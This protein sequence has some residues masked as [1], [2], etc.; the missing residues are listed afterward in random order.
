MV[1]RSGICGGLPHVRVVGHASCHRDCRR[2][3]KPGRLLLVSRLT[4]SSRRRR[5]SRC[6][7]NRCRREPT[8]RP[9]SGPACKTPC[10]VAVPA[11]DAGFS[12]T[13]TMPQVPAGHGSGPGDPQSPAIST[14]PATTTDRAQ[15]GGRGAQAGRAAAERCRK[16]MR[17][18]KPKQPKAAAAPAAASPFPNPPPLPAAPPAARLDFLRRIA[19]LCGL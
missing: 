2:R 15:P 14:T 18:K 10:S 13:F 16:P 1:R 6:S 9:R 17:P 5:R 11:P 3:G 12:V 19:E 7:W 4:P 8:P